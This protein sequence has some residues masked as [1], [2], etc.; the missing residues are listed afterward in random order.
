MKLKIAM[1]TMLGCMALVMA[2]INIRVPSVAAQDE[3]A[4]KVQPKEV[5]LC[6]DTQSDK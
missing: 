2:G 5:V 1:I 3:T 6:K 4:S